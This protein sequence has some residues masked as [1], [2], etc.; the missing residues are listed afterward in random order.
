M[1]ISETYKK[2]FNMELEKDKSLTFNFLQ[3]SSETN[4]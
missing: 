2:E 3:Y 4:Y 1:I